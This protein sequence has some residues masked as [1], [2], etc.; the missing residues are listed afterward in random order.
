M[1]DG[2]HGDIVQAQIP[3]SCYPVR[4]ALFAHIPLTL[5]PYPRIYN[6]LHFG[7]IFLGLR[8]VNLPWVAL[9]LSGVHN[10]RTSHYA[11]H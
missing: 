9:Y 2:I 7:R 11:V 4:E 5:D 1:I 10:M 8:Y 3:G 6:D